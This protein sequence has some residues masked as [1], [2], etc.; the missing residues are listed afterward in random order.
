MDGVEARPP[1][2]EC[3]QRR[4]LE[5]LAG[6]RE[7]L[8]GSL[9]CEPR[10]AVQRAACALETLAQLGQVWHDEPRGSRRCRGAGVRGEVAQRRVLFVP[11]RRDE[12]HR[13]AGDRPHDALVGER[14]QVLEAAAAARE[15]DHVGAARAEVADR[16]RDRRRRA[17]A[18]HVRLRHEHVRGRKALHDV[19]EH[20]ALRR[21]VVA[22]DETDQAREAG[23]SAF[24]ALL[25]QA[26]GGELLLQPLQRREVGAETEAL[27]R[28]R[29][30]PQLAPLRVELCAPEHVHSLSFAQAELERVELAPGHLDRA[31]S[32]RPR[33]PST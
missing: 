24:A 30:Q 32:P 1:A 18:L 9:G 15:H 3:E 19:R 27:D 29:L 5:T 14:Q 22:G 23:E 33:G 20:V 11:D 10:V 7:P 2:L 25:E 31:G 4:T 13:A 26:L 12:R 28:E 8:G 21:G 16:G 17:R 6:R